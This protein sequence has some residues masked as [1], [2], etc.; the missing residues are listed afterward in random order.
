MFF[1]ITALTSSEISKKHDNFFQ[2]VFSSNS[3]RKKAESV[4]Q[5]LMI[6]EILV[7]QNK[8]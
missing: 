2:F 3:I 6:E 4:F 1:D 7:K 5:I 8:N